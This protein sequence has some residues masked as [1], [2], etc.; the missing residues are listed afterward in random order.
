M[1]P[2]GRC[3]R[4]SGPVYSSASPVS[5]ATIRAA[6]ATI[7]AET[8]QMLALRPR[9]EDFFTAAARAALC[10]YEIIENFENL[11]IC[12]SIFS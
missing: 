5:G 9:G 3:P 11:A 1:L 7:Q 6:T 10:N 2:P 12:L 4:R 8:V